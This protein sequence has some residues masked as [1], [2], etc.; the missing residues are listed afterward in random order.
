AV[1]DDAL[2]AQGDAVFGLLGHLEGRFLLGAGDADA[3]GAAPEK[4]AA[5]EAAVVDAAAAGGD[6]GLVGGGLDGAPGRGLPRGWAKRST[7]VAQDGGG[8]L[9]AGGRQ[10]RLLFHQPPTTNH[11]PPSAPHQ[12]PATNHQ[13]P[14]ASGYFLSSF[15][16]SKV[17][18]CCSM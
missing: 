17:L 1:D 15:V 9:V 7:S 12:P 4:G 3:G 6:G 5:G 2:E 18:A 14:S 11:Q 13:L 10:Q 16:W 8:W